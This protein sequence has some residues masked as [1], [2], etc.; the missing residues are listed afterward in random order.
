MKNER[1]RSGEIEGCKRE[2]AFLELHLAK[3]PGDTRNWVLRGE[4]YQHLSSI[5]KRESFST[6]Q[7]FFGSYV[8]GLSEE[9]TRKAAASYSFL[10]HEDITKKNNLL[11]D[12]REDAED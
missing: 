5:S 1:D 2:A 4:I 9:H 8:A 3:N 7:L 6:E 10:A 12:L 11:K